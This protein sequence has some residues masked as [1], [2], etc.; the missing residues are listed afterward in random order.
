MSGPDGCIPVT[1]VH[2]YA[3]VSYTAKRINL[4]KR[5]FLEF[6]KKVEDLRSELSSRKER[7]HQLVRVEDDRLWDEHSDFCPLKVM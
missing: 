1:H 6:K 4:H 2:R 5:R 3:T 7:S